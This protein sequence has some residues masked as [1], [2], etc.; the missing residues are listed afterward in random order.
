LNCDEYREAIAADPAFEGGASHVAACSDCQ[1]YQREMLALNVKIAKAMQLGVPDLKMPELPKIETGNVAV[2]PA[3]KRWLN[4]MLFAV[5]ATVVLATSISLR[6]SGVF[7]SYG[8]LAEEVL[9][10]MDH[11]PGALRVTDQPVSDKRLAR[12]VPAKLAI[13]DR[14][15]SLITY[16]QPCKI[17]GKNVP[18]LVIQG[19]HG[20]I[21]ILL[22]PEEKIAEAMPI[23]GT[24]VKGLILP[25]GEGSIAIVGD[26]EEQLESIQKNVVSSVTWTT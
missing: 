14:D 1:A 20:P 11:E 6:V 5:A 8:S 24:N 19:E 13:F 3:R 15:A 9:A 10:H 17:N 16:A 7:Q 25:V 18:H 23:D 2:L 4:P 12:A 22:M 21:T 26:R